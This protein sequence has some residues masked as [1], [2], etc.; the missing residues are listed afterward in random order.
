M[1]PSSSITFYFK[2]IFPN[3]ASFNQYLKDFEVVDT[4]A[5]DNETLAKQIYKYLFRQFCNSNVQY[6]TPEDFKLSLANVIED[7]FEKY[8]QQLALIQKVHNMTAEDLEIISRALANTSQNPNSA[9]QD[10]EK[11]LE[12]I[13]A[14]AYTVARTGRLQAYLQAINAM[15]TKLIGEL[16]LSCKKLFKQILPTQVFYYKNMEE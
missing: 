16:I 7:M 15:P 5:A 11:P 13:T 3:F 9:P 12:Y 6:D 2:E 4:T 1:L 14:Q 8:K 10:I